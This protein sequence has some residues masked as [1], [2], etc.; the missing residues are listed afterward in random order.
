MHR[1]I[2]VNS[3]TNQSTLLCRNPVFSITPAI[4]AEQVSTICCGHTS[5]NWHVL[6]NLFLP[7]I[8]ASLLIKSRKLFG[9]CF[10]CNFVWK[11]RRRKRGKERLCKEVT[12][13]MSSFFLSFFLFFI[14][15][16]CFCMKISP[17]YRHCS[18]LRNVHMKLSF[19]A[20]VCFQCFSLV[21]F[22][23]LNGQLKKNIKCRK[24]N[25]WIILSHRDKQERA[26]ITS[27]ATLL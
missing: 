5:G 2:A 19:Q 10:Q 16:C 17:L 8:A 26:H 7:D 18:L 13:V 12:K 20:G 21:F 4:C 24:N 6:A 27:M 11:E 23:Q 25:A 3:R 14:F 22:L 15:V 9:N 1:L